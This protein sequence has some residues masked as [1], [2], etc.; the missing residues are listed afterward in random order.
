[1]VAKPGET[2]NDRNDRAIRVATGWYS[3]VCP[4]VKVVLLT[5]DAACRAAAATEGV[6]VRPPR[7]VWRRNII[8]IRC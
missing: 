8:S 3:R 2:P 7:Y 5:Q 6:M 1:M 4:G